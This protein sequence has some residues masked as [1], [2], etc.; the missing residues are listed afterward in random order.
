MWRYLDVTDRAKEE[1]KSA[2][3]IGMAIGQ[4][5]DPFWFP[6]EHWWLYKDKGGGQVIEQSTH[7]F[8][9]MRYLV[10]DVARVS[11]EIDN[12][13][14][15]SERPDMTSEDF[16]IVLMR[17]KSGAMGV[18]YSSCASQNTFSGTAVRIIAKELAL[19]H[20]GH[21]RLL[22]LMRTDHIEEVR[23][24][25]DALAEEDRVFVEAVRTGDMGRIRS[26]F[27]D[28]SKTLE[29]TVAANRAASER[30]VVTL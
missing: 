17:F 20:S 24:R 8:D 30:A 9:L 27:D 28:A 23:S 19:E 21:A 25:T 4:Y 22:R 3:P 29:V 16:S 14:V 2:G 12:I 18:V 6:P 7:V 13:I 1:L 5:V 26:T 15:S 11:A 10:G